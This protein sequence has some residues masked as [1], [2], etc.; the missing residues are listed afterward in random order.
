MYFVLLASKR[1]KETANSKIADSI[2]CRYL[3]IIFGPTLKRSKSTPSENLPVNFIQMMGVRKVSEKQENLRLASF[4][5][6]AMPKLMLN[7][8]LCLN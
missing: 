3:E 7:L 4:H 8:C 5:N 1:Y 2:F 6:E